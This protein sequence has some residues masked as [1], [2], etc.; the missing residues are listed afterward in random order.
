MRRAVDRAAADGKR[1]CAV[2]L[3]LVLARGLLRHVRLGRAA[4]RRCHRAA[5]AEM[6]PASRSPPFFAAS[7]SF[8]SFLYVRHHLHARSPWARAPWSMLVENMS[9]GQ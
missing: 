4:R 1:S 7:P 3:L 2:E 8:P 6:T 5:E 9:G